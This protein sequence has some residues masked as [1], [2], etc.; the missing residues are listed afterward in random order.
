MEKIKALGY[1]KNNLQIVHHVIGVVRDVSN[2]INRYINSL[3]RL[4]KL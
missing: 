3:D 2:K 4:L 1:N